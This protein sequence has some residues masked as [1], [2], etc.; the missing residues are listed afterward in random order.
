MWGEILVDSCDSGIICKVGRGGK[1][2][3]GLSPIVSIL[4]FKVF[5]MLQIFRPALHS[6]ACFSC[7]TALT[8]CGGGGEGGTP[9]P[10][11]PSGYASVI[12]DRTSLPKDTISL[13]AK[14][15]TFSFTAPTTN[16]E[17]LP[18]IKICFG[19]SSEPLTE[20]GLHTLSATYEI[21]TYDLSHDP[22]YKANLLHYGNRKLVVDFSTSA[23]P[24]GTTTTDM[25]NKIHVFDTGATP[26][27]E[28][29]QTQSRF[30]RP[31]ALS[32]LVVWPNNEG[33]FVVAYKP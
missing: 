16:I 32:Q 12:L 23:V 21:K 14:D 29:V 17:H 7:V 9:V 3:R 5:F 4:F 26:L 24:A 33:R 10:D 6:L 8:A 19:V 13:T 31:P 27:A 11:C 18:T 22:V 15:A 2:N 20:N 25:V 1:T 30:G 28:T